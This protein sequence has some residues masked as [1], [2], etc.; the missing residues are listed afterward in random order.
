MALVGGDGL[1]Q[2]LTYEGQGESGPSS[3]ISGVDGLCPGGY[4]MAK[5][6]AVKIKD[7]ILDSFHF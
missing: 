5:T 4:N 1:G 7:Q 6:G 2:V 3:K